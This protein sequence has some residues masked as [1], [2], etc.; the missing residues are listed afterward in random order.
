MASNRTATDYVLVFP[1]NRQDELDTK[2]EQLMIYLDDR[3]PSLT[4]LIG[5]GELGNDDDFFVA[6]ILGTAG[7]E[8]AANDPGGRR[9]PAV[10][11]A[12]MQALNDF[13]CARPN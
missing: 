6:P 1:L 9:A 4:F 3:F 7:G 5:E 12:I 10:E 13:E 11:D 2:R 8:F